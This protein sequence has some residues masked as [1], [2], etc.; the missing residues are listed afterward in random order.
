MGV[1]YRVPKCS[2]RLSEKAFS[3][4]DFSE[5]VFVLLCINAHIDRGQEDRRASPMQ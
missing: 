4:E 2:V 3:E 1:N 5:E